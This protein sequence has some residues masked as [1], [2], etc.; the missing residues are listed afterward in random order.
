[1]RASI[2]GGVAV[3]E[4]S[5]SELRTLFIAVDLQVGIHL[6]EA[7]LCEESA[8]CREVLA[9]TNRQGKVANRRVAG[10]LRDRAAGHRACARDAGDLGRVLRQLTQSPDVK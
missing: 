2:D 8:E 6:G 4:L 3:L 1:M 7:A 10:E 5:A 9:A